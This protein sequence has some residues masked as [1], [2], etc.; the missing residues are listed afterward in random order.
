MHKSIPQTRGLQIN[1]PPSVNILRPPYRSRVVVQAFVMDVLF[2]VFLLCAGHS[3]LVSCKTFSPEHSLEAKVAT[4]A[5]EP[6]FASLSTNGTPEASTACTPC[7]FLLRIA[8]G[9]CAS[10]DYADEEFV[11][12][13]STP[14][15]TQPT[16]SLASV[17]GIRPV[18]ASSVH[19]LSLE[20]AI[21]SVNTASVFFSLLFKLFTFFPPL[22][23]C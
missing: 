10:S 23:P 18:F 3:F 16:Q 17:F 8:D 5:R 13:A 6:L 19:N 7:H 2:T 14:S 4:Y 20:I 11:G 12:Q 9:S 21:S 22:V 15:D 1:N